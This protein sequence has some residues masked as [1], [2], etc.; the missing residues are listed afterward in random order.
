MNFIDKDLLLKNETAKKL[1]KDYAKDQP[2]FDFHCHFCSWSGKWTGFGR[3][4]DATG[5]GK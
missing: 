1:F 3:N 2:I 4:T 5:L